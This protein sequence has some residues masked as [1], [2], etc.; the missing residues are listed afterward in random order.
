M[1]ETTDRKGIKD[2]IENKP[3]KDLRESTKKRNGSVRPSCIV[4][5]G[6][7]S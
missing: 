5:F 1:L 2:I 4:A 3:L 7:E 6:E